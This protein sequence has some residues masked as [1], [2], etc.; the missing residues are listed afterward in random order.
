MML[1]K[2]LIKKILKKNTLL[3]FLFSISISLFA[4]KVSDVQ[5]L[6][7]I[8]KNMSAYRFYYFNHIGCDNE[9]MSFINSYL[10]QENEEYDIEI[11]NIEEK[12]PNESFELYKVVNNYYTILRNSNNTVSKISYYDGKTNE[13]ILSEKILIAFDKKTEKLIFVSG[14][15]FKNCISNDFNLNKKEPNSFFNFLFLKL[16]NYSIENLEFIKT[17]KNFLFFKGYSQ[18]LKDNVSIKVNID[19]FDEIQIKTTYSS[20][21][22]NGSYHWNIK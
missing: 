22:E 7:I 18:S 20:W 9:P 21:T 16:Y 4:Q 12:Y 2:Y 8:N 13:Q 5:K 6:K 15:V 17:R 3:Y 19:D 1:I 11:V 10:L 14:N